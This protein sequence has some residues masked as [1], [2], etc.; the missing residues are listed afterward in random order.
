[1]NDINI[2]RVIINTLNTIPI[3]GEENMAKMS[4]VFS[5]LHKMEDAS[6]EPDRNGVMNDG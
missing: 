1:M 5:L 4:G 6:K 2:F 3:A